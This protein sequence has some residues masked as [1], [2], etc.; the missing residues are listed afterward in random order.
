MAVQLI[1]PGWLPDIDVLS[2]ARR[3][4][5]LFVLGRVLAARR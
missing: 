5:L 4:D 3:G 1:V 2:T